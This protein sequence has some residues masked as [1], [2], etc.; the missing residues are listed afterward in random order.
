MARGKRPVRGGKR[1]F[2]RRHEHKPKPKKG[3]FNLREASYV[4][5]R[6]AKNEEIENRRK[7]IEEENARKQQL[8]T[9]SSEEEEDDPMKALLATFS[10]ADSI[11]TVAIESDSESEEEMDEYK[12]QSVEAIDSKDILGSD[13]GNNGLE[14]DENDDIIKIKE[15]DEEDPE[16]ARE[17]AGNL[18]D[19]FSIH[20]RNDLSDNLYEAVSAVPQ[21]METQKLTWPT[22]G[23]II[24]QIPKVSEKDLES[25]KQKLKVSIL[26]EKQFAQH[27]T[28]PHLINTINWNKLH[29]KSQIQNNIT[30]AN[31]ESITD[32]LDTNPSPLTPLQKELF[33]II[34]NYQDLY[35]SERTFKNE[36]QI[37]FIYCLHTI[38]HV[39]KTRTKV[40]HHNAKLSKLKKSDISEVPDEYRDQGLVRPK[41]LIIV[42]FRH[43][44]LKIVELLI[45]ILIGEDKGGSVVN[46]KR[47]MEDFS[48]NEI[49]LPKR[50]PK[51]EDYESTFKGNTDDTFKIGISI[52]KKTLKLYS[53]FYSSDIIISSV[54]GL[55]MLVGAEGE[56]DRDH[57]FLASIELL[58][59]DQTELF[60][61]QNWDHFLHVLNHLHLQPKD[62]HGTDFSRVRNWSVNGWSKYY[63]QSL[64]FSSVQLP[65][66]NAIF[67]KKCFNYAGKV[68]VS[69]PISS[70]AVCQVLVQLPQVFQKFDVS[71]H[72]QAIEARMNFF[73]TKI[74]PQYKDSIMNHTL[75]FVP[76]YFD[77][78]KLRNYFKKEELSFVQICEYS[79]DSKVAR[80]R[81]MFFHSDAHF[82]I[83]SERFHFFRR[84]R[85][86][87][88][89]HI[90]FYAPPTFPHFYSEICNLM[91]EANQN[92]RAGS[93]SNMTVTTLYC[94]YDAM[95]LTAIVGSEKAGRMITSEKTVH[96]LMTGE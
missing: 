76:S 57:D 23:T 50:N 40:L 39:L 42:P 31:Y 58:I 9:D 96:M 51:P 16:T 41:V 28:V 72:S 19:P 80:A 94:K 55:R 36:K 64:I 93:N 2:D 21:T 77:F 38:N 20:L 11:R 59:S 83:Y 32:T 48:G 54:L 24:I 73:L 44:C 18:R 45:S 29:I 89:R 34:N 26:E 53:E 17:D 13:D 35:Y 68:K 8:E 90:I 79:K 12:S 4:K 46:K 14:V 71:S 95:Q 5:E 52:T 69:N 49:A 87:G 15:D 66:I 91:Q 27:G 1:K 86:K 25:P 74:L 37:R 85:L 33:S 84:I 70:G 75:I 81:D 92:P 22:L 47:F 30:R 60:L 6:E 61:M 10:G 43:S 3:K 78:V 88:V 67:N 56:P 63:R 82:L 62:S 7:R 65:E